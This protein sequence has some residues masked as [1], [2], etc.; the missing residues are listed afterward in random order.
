MIAEQAWSIQQAVAPLT[1]RLQQGRSLILTLFAAPCQVYAPAC[2]PIACAGLQLLA[3]ASILGKV[4]EE[5]SGLLK[6][7]CQQYFVLHGVMFIIHQVCR[8]C[9]GW[10]GGRTAPTCAELPA[11]AE[12]GGSRLPMH[13]ALHCNTAR[14]PGIGTFTCHMCSQPYV[15]PLLPL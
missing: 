3:Y 5:A 4:L 7:S 14:V 8:G 2:D 10:C 15:T 9:G 11:S 6:G 12:Q 1:I 13:C